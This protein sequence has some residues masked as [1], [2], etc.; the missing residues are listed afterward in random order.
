MVDVSMNRCL[1]DLSEFLG[2]V[3]NKTN[4]NS[5]FYLNLMKF[6]SFKI[7]FCENYVD[8]KTVKEKIFSDRDSVDAVECDT[9]ILYLLL[10]HMTLLDHNKNIFM[11]SMKIS[12]SSEQHVTYRIQDLV[13]KK[14]QIHSKYL[15]FALTFCRCETKCSMNRLGKT[16]ILGWLS[17]TPKLRN[18]ADK[19]YTD[20]TT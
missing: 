15:L 4:V 7:L 5:F 2:S 20:D 16:K 1:M 8:T 18:L 17:R 9:D 12:N 10:H 11:S 3:S 6:E 14:D 13:E 19:F